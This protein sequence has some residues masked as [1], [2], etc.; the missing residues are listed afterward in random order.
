M[1][2]VNTYIDL[3]LNIH[4]HNGLADDDCE[5]SIG[6]RDPVRMRPGKLR[7]WLLDFVDKVA[8]AKIKESTGLDVSRREVEGVSK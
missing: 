7:A 5:V 4:R 8:P 1:P 2:A 6:G 3:S